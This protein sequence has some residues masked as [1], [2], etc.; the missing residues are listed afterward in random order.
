MRKLWRNIIVCLLTVVLFVMPISAVKNEMEI[1]E[2]P[3]GSVL[4]QRDQS[5]Y[6]DDLQYH[7]TMDGAAQSFTP[8]FPTLTKVKL[9]LTKDSGTHEFTAYNIVIYEGILDTGRPVALSTILGHELYTGT[10]WYDIGFPPAQVTP[11][12][13]YYIK[14]YGSHGTGGTGDVS[15]WYGYPDPYPRGEALIYTSGSWDLLY[16]PGSARSDF[17][18]QTWGEPGAYLEI[19]DVD[20]G[21]DM[22]GVTAAIRNSGSLDATNVGWDIHV[23]APVMLL[24]RETEGSIGTLSMGTEEEIATG[25]IFGFGPCTVT[26]TVAAGDVRASEEQDGFIIGPFVILGVV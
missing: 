17:V 16:G 11:G 6:D 22:V 13:V 24:G 2:W 9:W 8:T 10:T 21:F 15:W 3:C 20:G 18:F 19:V 1:E 5:S 14:L 26:V 7:I 12:K 23:D 25:F 4:D